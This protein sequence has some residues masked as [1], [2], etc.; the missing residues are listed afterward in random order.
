MY[1]ENVNFVFGEGKKKKLTVGRTVRGD[2]HNT[3]QLAFG[4]TT[5]NACGK[6]KQ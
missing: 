3:I 6:S 4:F 2:F 1:G 5:R